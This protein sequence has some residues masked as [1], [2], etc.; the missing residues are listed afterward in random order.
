MVIPCDSFE[1]PGAEK[2]FRTGEDMLAEA[3]GA[4]R[5]DLV[6]AEFGPSTSKRRQGSASKR[7]RN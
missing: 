3:R 7:R 6:D 5:V 4:E 2:V 1:V